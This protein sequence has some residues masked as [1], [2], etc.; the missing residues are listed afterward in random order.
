[1]KRGPHFGSECGFDI[2]FNFRPL[3]ALPSHGA[4]DDRTRRTLTLSL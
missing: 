2:R 4:A 1:M 3:C